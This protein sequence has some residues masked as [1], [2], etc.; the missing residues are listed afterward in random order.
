MKVKIDSKYPIEMHMTVEHDDGT[1]EHIVLNVSL[2]EGWEDE[3]GKVT[4]VGYFKT[5]DF[6]SR[7]K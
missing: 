6:L 4:A 1:L 7:I 3:W 5:E 2:I